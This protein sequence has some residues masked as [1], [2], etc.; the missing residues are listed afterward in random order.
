LCAIVWKEN[1]V[2]PLESVAVLPRKKKIR[3]Y[4]LLLLLLGLAVY[5]LLP[6]LAAMELAVLVVSSLKIPFVALSLGM[7]VLSYLS[8]GY[9]LRSLVNLGAKPVSIN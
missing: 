8:N 1:S 2:L 9:M 5:F 3:R 6:R 7:Q 4:L